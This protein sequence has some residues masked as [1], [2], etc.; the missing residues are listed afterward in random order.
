MVEVTSHRWHDSDRR[1]ASWSR[2]AGAARAGF[3]AGL[4][5]ADVARSRASTPGRRDAGA[6][7]ARRPRRRRVR[8]DARLRPLCRGRGSRRSRAAQRAGAMIDVDE[9]L[10]P[11]YSPSSTSGRALRCVRHRRAAARGPGRPGAAV[12]I[13]KV[14][15]ATGSPRSPRPT[16]SARCA[17]PRV[18]QAPEAALR[19]RRQRHA[20]GPSSRKQSWPS[21][22]SGGSG[23][24][25]SR[26]AVARGRS[27]PR[28]SCFVRALGE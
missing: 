9:A 18:R 28:S 24:D 13:R 26:R 21:R 15:V 7:R 4:A 22:S 3:H 17:L 8:H 6:D 19:P 10:L 20:Q 2:R 12:L 1:R 11:G 14:D 23:W 16:T 5:R 25:A 27:A